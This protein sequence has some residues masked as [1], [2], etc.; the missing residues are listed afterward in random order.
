MVGEVVLLADAAVAHI[1]CFIQYCLL[2][3]LT[4]ILR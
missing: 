3:S 4:S 2:I 1:K